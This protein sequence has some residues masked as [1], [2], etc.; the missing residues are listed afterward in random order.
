MVLGSVWISYVC[1][2]TRSS[3]SWLSVKSQPP[4]LLFKGRD[5]FERVWDVTSFGCVSSSFG[6]LLLLQQQELGKGSVSREDL[7]QEP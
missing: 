3:Q 1:P 7:T 6:K 5:L 2:S 4:N